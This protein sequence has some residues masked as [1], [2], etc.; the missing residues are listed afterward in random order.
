[1]SGNTPK[2]YDVKK[3]LKSHLASLGLLLA[4]YGAVI[5]YAVLCSGWIPFSEHIPCSTFDPPILNPPLSNNY[6]I[7]AFFATSLLS[8]IIGVTMLCIY[9][10]QVIRS[11][12]T[13]DSEHVAILLVVSGFAYQVL[14]AW[15]LQETA[16]FPW[17]W[18]KLIMGYGPAFA[19]GL[20]LLSLV[21]LVIGAVSL[22]VHSQDYHRRHPEVKAGWR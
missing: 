18:Q 15:P 10:I 22:F 14:G 3:Y 13:A 21:A 20:Y 19:W 16:K 5:T 11:C 9:S 12:I 17:E 8:L 4:F 6:I 7:P 2:Q 1:M